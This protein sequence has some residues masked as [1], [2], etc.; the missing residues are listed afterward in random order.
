MLFLSTIQSRKKK[1]P[2]QAKGK[3]LSIFFKIKYTNYLSFCFIISR[4]EPKIVKQLKLTDLNDL[5][6]CGVDL[7]IRNIAATVRHTWHSSEMHES[8]VL[9]KSKDYHYKAGKNARFGRYK[10]SLSL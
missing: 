7:G 6:V 4:T 3:F 9:H 5:S 8:N 2:V 1:V 10:R